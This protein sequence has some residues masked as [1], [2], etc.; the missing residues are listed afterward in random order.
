MI[1]EVKV[2]AN[3]EEAIQLIDDSGKT[4]SWIFYNKPTNFFTQ[5]VYESYKPIAFLYED[6]ELKCAAHHKGSKVEAFD[7]SDRPFALSDEQITLIE[8][9]I[10]PL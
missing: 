8:N 10:K 5:K 4:V 2:P 1:V 6:G 3:L 7:T 9:V